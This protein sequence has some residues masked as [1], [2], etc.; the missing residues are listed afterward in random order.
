MKGYEMEIESKVKRVEHVAGR[1]QVLPMKKI[2]HFLPEL[3]NPTAWPL[4]AQPPLV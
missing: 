1:I 2:L 3:H 4:T